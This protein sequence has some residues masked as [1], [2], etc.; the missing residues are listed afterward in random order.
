[1]TPVATLLFTAGRKGRSRRASF[2]H[3]CHHISHGRTAEINYLMIITTIL[4]EKVNF[5]VR[6]AKKIC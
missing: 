1:M 3:P 2:P 4:V 6:L 5:E